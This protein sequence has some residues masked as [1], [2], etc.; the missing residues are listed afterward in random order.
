MT[1]VI[2][3]RA[4]CQSFFFSKTVLAIN[5]VAFILLEREIA[6]KNSVYFVGKT[7]SSSYQFCGVYFWGKTNC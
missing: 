3:Y 1:V 5:L 7:I 4:V 2:D 6:M